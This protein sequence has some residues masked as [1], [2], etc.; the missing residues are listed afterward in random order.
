MQDLL[1][2]ASLSFIIKQGRPASHRHL[3]AVLLCVA[4]RY[5]LAGLP[6]D[7]KGCV[8]MLPRLCVLVLPREGDALPG[9]L[10]P[11]CYV[12]CQRP[13]VAQPCRLAHLP[14]GMQVSI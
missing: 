5:C 12:A 11:S 7:A 13:D 4:Y 1:L 6:G 9:L 10:L 3:Q 2:A 8:G 14:D